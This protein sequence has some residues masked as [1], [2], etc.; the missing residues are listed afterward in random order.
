MREKKLPIEAKRCQM[1]AGTEKQCRAPRVK[2]SEYCFFHAPE[3]QD[4]RVALGEKLLT[5][6][7]LN[8]SDLHKFLVETTEAVRRKRL[9]PQ[10]AYALACLVKMIGENLP[11]VDRELREHQKM[12][13]VGWAPE[14]VE[15]VAWQEVEAEEKQPAE[16]EKKEDKG[17]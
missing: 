11:A 3:V 8:H 4:E 14:L 16:S 13:Y 7:W 1:E 15:K 2:D 12:G 17:E 6:R 5:L 10:R 9:D